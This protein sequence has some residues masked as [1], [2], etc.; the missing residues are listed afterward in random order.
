MKLI[1]K[2]L[3]S[4]IIVISTIVI[5][6]KFIPEMNLVSTVNAANI[7]LNKK[8]KSIYKG[9]TYTLK[10]TGTSKKVTWTSSNKKIATV[11]SKGKVTAKQKGNV[12]ITAKVGK[13][14]LNC[15]V[16]VKSLDFTN[17]Q[18]KKSF[19]DYLKIKSTNGGQD[20]LVWLTKKGKLNYKSSKDKELKNGTIVTNI[21]FS[22]YKKAMLNYVSKN[23]FEK[24]WNSKYFGKNSKGYLTTVNGG[25]SNS[26]YTIKSITKNKNTK[27]TAKTSY[28]V[29]KS[30]STRKYNKKFT[31]TVKAYNN[32]CVIDSVSK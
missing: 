16:K 22:D 13:R 7:K 18:V 32:K 28:I 25:G 5:T 10:V 14:K 8:S 26:V 29:D 30:E 2:L 27:Y 21:K 15:K 9:D 1:K 12:T 6:P 4:I 20:L 17:K 31:F 3:L 23:E 11:N 19:S 24:N